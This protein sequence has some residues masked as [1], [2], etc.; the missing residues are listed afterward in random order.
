MLMPTSLCIPC[1]AIVSWVTGK[2]KK[3]DCQYVVDDPT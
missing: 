1:F 3:A 2:A